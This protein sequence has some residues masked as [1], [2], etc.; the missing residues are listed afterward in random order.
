[1]LQGYV[2]YVTESYLGPSWSETYQNKN[3]LKSKHNAYWK[4]YRLNQQ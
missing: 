2:I 1:M 4:I 3:L